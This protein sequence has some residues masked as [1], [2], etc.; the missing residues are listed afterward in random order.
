MFQQSKLFMSVACAPWIQDLPIPKGPF[1]FYQIGDS[2]VTLSFVD[3]VASEIGGTEFDYRGV[4]TPQD[5]VGEEFLNGLNE[6]ERAALPD[7]IMLLIEQQRITFNYP[8]Q[9]GSELSCD[10]DDSDDTEP[11]DSPIWS[12]RL[13]KKVL[14]DAPAGAYL[15]SNIG[16]PPI[17]AEYVASSTSARLLQWGRIIEVAANGRLCYMYDSKDA[18]DRKREAII[19]QM[20]NRRDAVVKQ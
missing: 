17:F 7:V 18:Y 20:S 9:G 6:K 5:Y 16:G 15:A 12:G 4:L 1:G 8:S 2:T 10:D 3:K 14:F 13:T 19:T 11:S